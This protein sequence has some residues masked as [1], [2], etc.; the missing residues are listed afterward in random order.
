[1]KVSTR[2]RYALRA[3]IELALHFGHGPLTIGTI[4]KNEGISEKYLENIMRMFSAIG[5]VISSKG[6]KGGFILS[7]EPSK[8]TMEEILK[9][10]EGTISPVPCLDNQGDCPKYQTC[11]ALSAWKGY[12]DAVQNYLSSVNLQQLISGEIGIVSTKSR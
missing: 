1:M 11:Q 4:A 12:H 5:L 3:M 8:I 7:R 10:T 9:I 6:N 2:G